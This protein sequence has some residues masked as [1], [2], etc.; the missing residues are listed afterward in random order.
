MPVSFF[1]PRPGYGL[2]HARLYPYIVCMENNSTN[3]AP[4]SGWT[5]LYGIDDA[6]GIQF[7]ERA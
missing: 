1:S 3:A 6:E 5:L 4:R 7:R 2:D